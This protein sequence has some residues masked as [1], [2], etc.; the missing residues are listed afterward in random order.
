M[1]ES[2]EGILKK[3]FHREDLKAL[4]SQIRDH[5]SLLRLKRRWLMDLPLSTREQKKMAEILIFNDKI[6]PESFLREDDVS[7]EDIRTCVETTFGAHNHG[8]EPVSSHEDASALNSRDALQEIFLMLDAMT[9]KSLYSFVMILTGGVVKVEKTKWS[10]KRTI[11]ELLPEVIAGKNDL[12][13][14]KLKQISQLLQDPN[15]FRGNQIVLSTNSMSYCAAAIKV[16]DGLEDFRI[17]ALSAMHRKLNGVTGYIPSMKPSKSGGRDNLVCRVRKRCMKLLSGISEVD[18]PSGR[19]VGALGV[20]GLTLKLMMNRPDVRDFRRFPPEI[21]ALQNDIMKAIHLLNDAK[22]VSLIELK[23]VQILLNPNQELSVRSLRM[24]I[25]NWLTECLYECSDMDKVPDYLVETLDIIN[26]RSQLRSSKKRSSSELH[27]SPREIMKEVIEKEV[28]CVLTISAQAKEVVSNLLP[29]HDFDEEFARAY[30]EDYE[31]YDTLCVSDDDEQERD[32]SQHFEF[33]SDNSYVQEESIG[34]TKP[35]ELHSPVS[36]GERDG[37]SPHSPIGTLNV[38]LESMYVT[39]M[40]SDK[41]GG[42][43]YSPSSNELKVLDSQRM[44]Q[45]QF[46]SMCSGEYRIPFFDSVKM[47][48]KQDLSHQSHSASRNSCHNDIK[49]EE[50]TSCSP[51]APNFVFSD[52]PVEETDNRSQKSR[53]VNAYLEVQEACDVTSMIAYR[54]VGFVLDKLAKIEGLKLYQGDRLYLNS[55]IPVPEDSEDQHTL[56]ASK[57]SEMWKYVLQR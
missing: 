27:S 36:T 37:C 11:T 4:T 26:R 13:K 30:M 21:E 51:A 42:F 46:Q 48:T 2:V 10:M 53:A 8:K 15:S 38:H 18:E 44:D 41:T 29:E 20:A 45:K 14:T 34:E 22:K 6:L 40:D 24:A 57:F 32:T 47:S 19:L 12:S 56:L 5:E 52:F 16:L 1:V 43:C 49:S 7:Y 25:R 3:E 35:E 54:F 28:E 9:N 23:K 55:Y 33:H 17:R 31:V 39:Q 50:T